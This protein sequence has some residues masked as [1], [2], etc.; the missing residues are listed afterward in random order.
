MNSGEHRSYCFGSL[1]LDLRRGAL[2]AAD[3]TDMPLRA[4]SF[5]LLRLL[6]ENAGSLVARETVMETLWP[7][8]YVTD[9]NITQCIVD[10]RRALGT[11]QRQM[12][13]TINRR[14]YLFLASV[15]PHRSLRPPEDDRVDESRTPEGER[16]LPAPTVRAAD[17]PSIAVLA[18][19]NLSGDPRREYFSDG[20]ADDLITELARDRSLFVVA[21][22]SSFSYK[23]RL[24][25]VKRIA[26]ELDVRYVIDGSVRRDRG[27]LRVTAR[28]VDA[29]TGGHLWAERF[30]RDLSNF[31]AVQDRII[32]AMV[33]A[34]DSAIGKVERMRAGKRT[35][36]GLDAWQAWQAWQRVAQG[37]WE[38]AEAAF[39]HR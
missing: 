17:R 39:R 7:N 8:I 32:S 5:A 33:A 30:D 13:R 4:K 16:L 9:D 6:V 25:D 10:I 1:V 3:G 21:R 38:A 2:V 31:F 24:V 15:T 27:R 18:F 14:G 36:E 20:V 23:G 35:A 29:E 26:R 22:T 34:I 19:A 12:L 37:G 28:L 11:E